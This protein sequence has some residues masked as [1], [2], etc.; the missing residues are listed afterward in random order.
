MPKK[1]GARV[2]AGP[3]TCGVLVTKMVDFM[4]FGQRWRSEGTC[5]NGFA[6]EGNLI[7]W[8]TV[9]CVLCAV[10][11]GAPIVDFGSP[12]YRYLD[13]CGTHQVYSDEGRKSMI[14]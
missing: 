6:R 7:S 11:H 1:C 2:E 9:C 10:C 5:P 3:I 14:L 4:G 12:K 8:H 13:G